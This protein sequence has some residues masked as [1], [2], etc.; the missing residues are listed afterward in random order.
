MLKVRFYGLVEVPRDAVAEYL[1]SSSCQ[2]VIDVVA[3][4]IVFFL[5]VPDLLVDH[6]RHSYLQMG[7][8]W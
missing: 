8:R 3:G 1:V 5:G 4:E 7:R 6:L 2:D